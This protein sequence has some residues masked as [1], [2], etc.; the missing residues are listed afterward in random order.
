MKR[1]TEDGQEPQEKNINIL[2]DF[3]RMEPSIVLNILSYRLF[4]F[5]RFSYL[6]FQSSS[7]D[8]V[9]I[10]NLFGYFRNEPLRTIRKLYSC[11]DARRSYKHYWAIVQFKQ[12]INPFIGASFVDLQ[13]NEQFSDHLLL[14]SFGSGSENLRSL[15]LKNTVIST[16]GLVQLFSRP[17]FNSLSFLDIENGGLNCDISAAI[18]AGMLNNCG[19]LKVLKYSPSVV[20]DQKEVSPPKKRKKEDQTNYTE[21]LAKKC[22]KLRLIKLG[23]NTNAQDF[24]PLLHLSSLS[25]IDLLKPVIGP[26]HVDLL[27]KLTNLRSARIIE[28]QWEKGFSDKQFDR[29]AK[30]LEHLTLSK[31]KLKDSDIDPFLS[32]NS[33]LKSLDLSYNDGITGKFFFNLAN[34]P[35]L[36]TLNVSHSK[37]VSGKNL[38]SLLSSYITDLDLSNC[39]IKDNKVKGFLSKLPES[40]RRLNLAG[41]DLSDDSLDKI[42][43][44]KSLREIDLSGNINLF[45]VGKLSSMEVVTLKNVVSGKTNREEI[46]NGV[47][48]LLSSKT[49]RSIS[50]SGNKLKKI[51]VEALTR[52]ESLTL[53]DLSDNDITD[54]VSQALFN[55]ILE[56]KNKQPLVTLNLASNRISFDGVAT[57]QTI[58]AKLDVET[59]NLRN[60]DLSFNPCAT[61]HAIMEHAIL[62]KVSSVIYDLVMEFLETTDGYDSGHDS[63]FEFDTKAENDDDHFIDEDD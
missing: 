41:N 7:S 1:K 29:W 8:M 10:S 33:S 20:P 47:N 15:N 5:N 62:D 53:L 18:N 16:Q 51:N 6:L 58:N 9:L 42:I 14:C 11:I 17:G 24:S 19:A 4:P 36:T 46:E 35:N 50:I 44:N 55:D 60:L 13:D 45:E 38:E 2:L 21:I 54:T 56:R 48:K 39:D 23:T 34:C 3:S 32:K 26:S 25:E 30:N 43:E 27:A 40:L 37:K 59:C 22:S 52:S 61:D 12:S 28:A 57:L 49:L 31:C 63:D